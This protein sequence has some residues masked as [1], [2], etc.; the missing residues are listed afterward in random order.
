MKEVYAGDDCVS[1]KNPSQYVGR[2]FVD[3]LRC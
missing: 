1:I 2:G 3:G